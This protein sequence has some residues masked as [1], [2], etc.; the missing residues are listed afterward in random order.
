MAHLA[1]QYGLPILAPDIEDLVEL[2]QQEQ[3]SMEFFSANSDESMAEQ[4]VAMFR[5]PERLQVMAHA[6]FS[7][8]LQM[9]MPQIIREYTR[10]FDMHQ[11]VRML[12]SYSR[13]RRARNGV[14]GRRWMMRQIERDLSSRANKT[15][16]W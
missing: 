1:C 13:L 2:A 14:P 7:A 5:S 4:L 9:S 15:V 6:N 10:S 12:K 11:R 16:D 8:A 3:V